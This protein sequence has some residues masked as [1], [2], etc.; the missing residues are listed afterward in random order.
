MLLLPFS[1]ILT[2]SPVAF[3]PQNNQGTNVKI[4]RNFEE[5]FT[6]PQ[7]AN[8]FEN[9]DE[10]KRVKW[11]EQKNKQKQPLFKIKMNRGGIAVFGLA[12]QPIPTFYKSKL[13]KIS[14]LSSP[15]CIPG[16]N[17][18][19]AKIET[20]LEAKYPEIL[21][22]NS[23]STQVNRLSF[24][25]TENVPITKQSTYSDGNVVAILNVIFTKT[26]PPPSGFG[27]GKTQRAIGALLWSKYENLRNECNGT[28]DRRVTISITYVSNNYF[29]SVRSDLLD[30]QREQ[31]TDAMENL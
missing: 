8:E 28:G 23:I 15:Q 18:L 31:S 20:A 27:G 2:V 9:M 29:Q 14:L 6:L 5:G 22:N 12:L 1:F 21:A 30:Q 17:N 10:V 26:D 16:T 11:K 3:S 4:W 7:T 19:V 13:Q 25:A 24:Q